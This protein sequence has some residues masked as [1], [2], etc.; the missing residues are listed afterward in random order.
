MR[1]ISSASGGKSWMNVDPSSVENVW[2]S[3]LTARTSA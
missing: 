3:R 2:W 1:T